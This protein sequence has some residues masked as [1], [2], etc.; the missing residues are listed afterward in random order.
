MRHQINVL[1]KS[2]RLGSREM[3]LGGLCGNYHGHV[4][5]FPYGYSGQV[6][7][8]DTGTCTLHCH[9]LYR[10][11]DVP[12]CFRWCFSSA[13]LSI[14]VPGRKCPTTPQFLLPHNMCRIPHCL[15]SLSGVAVAAIAAARCK[16]INMGDTSPSREFGVRGASAMLVGR[17]T[18]G[19]GRVWA[20]QARG[21][22]YRHLQ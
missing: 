5:P 3:A 1:H 7:W 17:E 10:F 8:A 20:R 6:L 21:S 13:S 2:G 19:G 16:R 14:L 22:Q 15:E 11:L 18:R 12:G 9:G 4:H